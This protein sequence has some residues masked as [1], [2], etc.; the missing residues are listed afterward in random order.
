MPD[1]APPRKHGRLGLYAPFAILLV[2]IVAWTGYWF[3]ARIQTRETLDLQAQALRAAGYEV[4]W[5]TRSLGGYPFRMDVT[6]TDAVVRDPSGW[7][8]SA[9]RLE[10]EAFMHA[11][12]HWMLAT[13]QGLSFNR[14]VG[15]PVEVTGKLLRASF[16]GF[17]KRPPSLSFEGVDLAFAAAPGA[18][19]FPLTTAGRVEFHLRPGPDDE[20]GV[21]LKVDA[22]KARGG[23]LL[24]RIAGDKPVAIRWNSTLSK[25]SAMQGA[26]WP[27]MVRAWSTAGGAMKLRDAGIGA[28]DAGVEA[29]GGQ[30]TVG[31]DGRAR[32]VLDVSIRQPVR[33]VEALAQS[34]V[35]APE[36]AQTAAAV[37]AA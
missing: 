15:G 12:G 11:L 18:Q 23:L 8:L 28:G 5:K 21:F 25:M 29:S 17:D 22:G 37:L 19:P 1:T 32:G 13:P 2:A 24:A 35:I 10:G 31:G 20:G 30:F 6:L 3:W 7:A 26:N 33:V 16:T 14:P 9:P 36:T 27:A 4:S 34:G